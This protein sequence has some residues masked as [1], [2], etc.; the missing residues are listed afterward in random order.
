VFLAYAAP[1]GV[2]LIDRAL[3]LPKVW[4]D[5]RE[6]CR[7]AGIGDEVGFATKPQLGQA[8]LERAVAAGVPFR[9]VTGDSVY[10]SVYGGDRRLR[11]WLEQHAIPHVMAVKRTEPLLAMTDRGPVR[12]PPSGCWP[13]SDPSSGCG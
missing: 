13:R 2:A 11:V 3:Y 8:M 6:R 9:W 12:S 5:D 7:P 10:G 1:A 4:T